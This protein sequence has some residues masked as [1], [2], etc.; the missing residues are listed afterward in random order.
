MLNHKII[1]HPILFSLLPI[2]FLFQHNINEVP[3]SV[4]LVPLGLS[5]V[6]AIILWIPLKILFGYTKSSI[7]TSCTLL[8]FAIFGNLHNVL[9]DHP[10]VI[11]QVLGKLS[12]LGTI[13]LILNI[14]FAIFIIKRKIIPNITNPLNV[15]SITIV[16]FLVVS[17]LGYYVMNPI[18]ENLVNYFDKLDIQTPQSDNKPDVYMFVLDEFSGKNTLKLDFDYDLQPFENKLIERGFF[19]PA[20]S[21]SNYPHTEFSMPAIMNM[22]Y[23]DKLV[24]GMENNSRDLQASLKVLRTNNVMKI[25]KANDYDVVTFYGGTGNSYN[26]KL[27]DEKLCAFVGFNLD[28]TKNFVFTYLPVSYF[29]KVLLENHSRE[30]LECVF[31]TF[32]D[33][34]FEDNSKSKFVLA[35]LRL[36]HEPFVYDE[37]GN[38][39]QN[40]NE[41]NKSAYLSQLKFTETKMVEIVDTIQSHSPDAVIILLSDHGY[42]GEINWENPK[43]IDYMRAFNTITAFYF[44]IGYEKIPLEVS[45]VN[46]LRIFFNSYFNADFEILENRHMWYGEIIYNHT[47]VSEIFKET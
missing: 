11:L 9:L 21:F 42:R 22:M 1:I 2:L 5:V 43:K 45:S 31:K 38:I 17:S 40:K 24:A 10:E 4:I 33:N 39:M 34:A 8:S 23:M 6:P 44:P 12:I 15:M 16:G 29:N 32:E 25:F 37:N 14:I 19:V 20:S 47:K 28:L 27:V 13:F 3:F 26:T 46:V 41:N 35:H 7:I 36:P 30:K 18:D